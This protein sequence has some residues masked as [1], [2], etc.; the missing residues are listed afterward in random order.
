LPVA[1]REIEKGGNMNGSP[2]LD[3]NKVAADLVH[4]LIMDTG[5]GLTSSV[6]DFF[7]RLGDVINKDVKPYLENMIKKCCWVKTLIINREGP[8][9]L[10][11]IYVK[12]RISVRGKVVQDDDLISELPS[13]RSV[14]IEGNGGS[15]KS[16]LMRYLFISLCEKSFG[17]LPVFIELRT[18]NTFNTKDLITFIYR[19]ITGPGAVLTR[20]QFENGLRVGSF[21]IILDGFDEVDLDQ[22]SNIEQQIFAL[23]EKYPELLIV[24]SSRPDPDDRFQSW[25]KFHVCRVQPMTQDQITELVDK[26]D[27]DSQIKK[28][29]LKALKESLFSTHK[30]F[31]SN[32]LLSIMMLITFEQ[33]GHIPDKMH[34][35]YEHAFDA[36]FFRHDAAKEGLYRRKTHG[37]LPIDEFR[38]CL[39]AFCLV[40]YSK[41]RF[42]FTNTEVRET[43]KSAMSLERKQIEPT[44]FL[45]DLVECVCLLQMEGLQ[46][47]FTHRSFQEYFA[48]C[49][50]ARSPTGSVAAM[51]DQFCKRREDNV[52]RMAFAMNRKLLEREWILPKLTE[53]ADLSKRLNPKTRA[54]EYIV[55]LFGGVSLRHR[56][57][58]D[59]EFIFTNVSAMGYFLLAVRDLYPEQYQQNSVGRNTA[60]IKSALK[61]LVEA[62]DS[63]LFSI[64]ANRVR[65]GQ[66]KIHDADNTWLQKTRVPSYFEDHKTATMKVL[67][68]VREAVSDQSNA[69]AELL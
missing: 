53:F 8:T 21:C 9:Y 47:E 19:S 31:L 36:L 58:S 35:F 54:L 23:R 3:P 41:E 26:L 12:T 4:R 33:Y 34:I 27:Y 39:S 50:I 68:E 69:L 28:K 60:V 65:S 13:L 56:G 10:F 16:M 24:V 20:E 64:G 2:E 67:S 1:D 45:N 38:D 57:R 14:V 18:L 48:A 6:R 63:R 15:G 66:F 30:S 55:T 22:R 7:S 59:G 40:S 17:K 43:I 37:N 46:Y 5:K 49:F 52:V 62:G 42:T 25:S 51:L 29:F 61:D 11:D 44:D 32:P